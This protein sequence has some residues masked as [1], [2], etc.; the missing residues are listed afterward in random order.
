M[1]IEFDFSALRG[2]IVEKYGTFAAFADAIGMSRASLSQR[3][4]NDVAF[5]PDEVILICSPKVLD[6]APEEIGK[7]FYTPKV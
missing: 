1:P 2:R 6:I 7:F 4:M 5:K 3:I